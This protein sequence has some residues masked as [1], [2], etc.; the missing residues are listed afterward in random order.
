VAR[1]WQAATARART[2]QR[3]RPD[4]SV[5]VDEFHNFLNMPYSLEDILPESRGYH[6]GWTLAHQNL[7]QLHRELKE[8][9]STNARSKIIY[10]A[11]PEDARELA[12]HTA[13][14]LSA[15]D[16]SHLDTYHAAARL[17][18]NGGESEP[19]TMLTNPMPAPIPGRSREIRAA[20]RAQRRSGVTADGS[21]TGPPPRADLSGPSA[22]RGVRPTRTPKTDPRRSG[23]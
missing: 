3:L 6:V 8:G 19:F 18:T 16:L 23:S 2:P 5:V 7:A 11:S 1:T 4:A 14:R 13:P 10:S 20:V 17:V 12:L 22:T 9:L 21:T 15:H